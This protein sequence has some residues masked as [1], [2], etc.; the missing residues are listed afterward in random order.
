MDAVI[1]AHHGTVAIIAAE[2]GCDVYSFEVNPFHLS[3]L[4]RN[5]ARFDGSSSVA[6]S[7]S[8][9]PHRRSTAGRVHV[10]TDEP[11]DAVV[12][13]HVVPTM[14]K[15]DTDGHDL[16]VSRNARRL[17]NRTFAVHIE[18]WAEA[19]GSVETLRQ[20]LGLY[21]RAGLTLWPHFY[22]EH[23]KPEARA[24]LPIPPAHSL[25]MEK[26]HNVADSE[27]TSKNVQELGNYFC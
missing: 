16:L 4:R 10:F 23:L 22:K 6:S 13:P 25:P 18:V 21:A 19:A 12:P 2:A 3:V 1:D 24:K 8:V 14:V 17:I 5:V 9:P 11:A 15:V 7:G 20:L 26:P 27:E